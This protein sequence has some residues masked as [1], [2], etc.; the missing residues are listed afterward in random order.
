MIEMA[1]QEDIN[2]KTVKQAF[3][4]AKNSRTL[5]SI[6]EEIVERKK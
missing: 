4:W 6:I 3:E 2:M 1:L 5:K